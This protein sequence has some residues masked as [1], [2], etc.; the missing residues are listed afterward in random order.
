MYL[1]YVFIMCIYCIHLYIYHCEKK[2]RNCDDQD[3]YISLEL[4]IVFFLITEILRFHHNQC[5][6]QKAIIMIVV[7]FISC[8]ND[9]RFR[10]YMRLRFLLS[11]TLQIETHLRNDWLQHTHMISYCVRPLK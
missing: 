6:Y 1:Q 8:D 7:V 9:N 4:I 10:T 2:S 11:N 5:S 3:N